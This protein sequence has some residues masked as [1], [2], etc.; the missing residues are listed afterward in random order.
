[1]GPMIH[2]S[3]L[4]RAGAYAHRKER[5]RQYRRDRVTL[6]IFGVTMIGYTIFLG[7]LANGWLNYK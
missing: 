6:T 5:E 2:E 4:S 1:M 3:E 7:F